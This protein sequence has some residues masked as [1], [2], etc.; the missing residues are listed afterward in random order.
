MI[1]RC[2]VRPY[3]VTSVAARAPTA[4]AAAAAP[5]FSL[6]HRLDGRGEQ[7]RRTLPRLDRGRHDPRA[8]RLGQHE[9]V[10]GP[11]AVV[12]EHRAGIDLAHR[13]H[14]V[15]GLARRRS[16][17]P[18]A[19]RSPPR[20][21]SLLGTP[22]NDLLGQSLVQQSSRKRQQVEREERPPPHGVHVRERVG[23]RDPSEVV[24]IV[25]D[26]REEVH[27][28]DQSAVVRDTVHGRVVARA[29]VDEHAGV[30][31]GEEGTQNLRQLGLAE[32]TRSPGA[33]G[34]GA[35]PDPGFLVAGFGGHASS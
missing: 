5:R 13:D 15:L 18:P 29:G 2:P 28:D 14:S 8:E 3:P 33:V 35:E 12:G 26:G 23:G 20:L 22:A 31:G 10:A 9:I 11:R 16:S 21:R 30:H 17:D 7:P 4:R 1:P 25:H 27:G 34:Q 19:P 24:R 32:L 6:R